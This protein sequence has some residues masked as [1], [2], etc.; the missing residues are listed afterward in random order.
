MAVRPLISLT[1]LRRRERESLDVAIDPR[2]FPT[3]LEKLIDCG[4]CDARV[5]Q[6]DTGQQGQLAEVRQPRIGGLLAEN[7]DRPDGPPKLADCRKALIGEVAANIRERALR[8][9]GAKSC[10]CRCR[11]P[12]NDFC[13]CA[14]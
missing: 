7:A 2:L 1:V 4:V 6:T 9:K 10:P 3:L 11:A 13:E 12:D 8:W 5:E 14:A